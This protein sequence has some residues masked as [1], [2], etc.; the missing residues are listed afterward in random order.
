MSKWKCSVNLPP[1]VKNVDQFLHVVGMQITVRDDR[2]LLDFEHKDPMQ[3]A[4]TYLCPLQRNIEM[5]YNDEDTCRW[6]VI[7]EG[8]IMV[9]ADIQDQDDFPEK[10]DSI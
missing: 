8:S 4:K 1:I 5:F 2:F 10:D 6:L 3:F 9:D 7:R